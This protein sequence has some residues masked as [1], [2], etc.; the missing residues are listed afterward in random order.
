[1]GRQDQFTIDTTSSMGSGVKGKPA[2]TASYITDLLSELQTIAN[3]S[4]L[5][6]LSDDINS[7]LSKHM[8]RS[9]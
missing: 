7:V 4:G 3:I 5:S 2:E 1:M 6:V 9:V 8:T